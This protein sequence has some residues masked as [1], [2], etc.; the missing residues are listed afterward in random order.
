MPA[1]FPAKRSG[2]RWRNDRCRLL[3]GVVETLSPPILYG[4]EKD[5]TPEDVEHIGSYN[6][7]RSQRPTIVVPG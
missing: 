6:W 7:I 5:V 2:A 3:Y 1:Q 4:S